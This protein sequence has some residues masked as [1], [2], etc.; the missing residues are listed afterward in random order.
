MPDSTEMAMKLAENYS[1]E[2]LRQIVQLNLHAMS[3]H[4]LVENER[5]MLNV[6]R[7]QEQ[8]D[9]MLYACKKVTDC[10]Q[11]VGALQFGKE[12]RSSAAELAGAKQLVESANNPQVMALNR[13]LYTQ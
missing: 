1:Y 3:L 13:V 11:R 10:A 4:L 2:H 12:L 8:T 6:N 9:L 7:T 5:E